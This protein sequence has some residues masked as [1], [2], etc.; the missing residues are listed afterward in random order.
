MDK[1]QLIPGLPDDLACE[2][3]VRVSVDDFS[4]VGAVCNKWNRILGSPLFDKHRKSVGA[5]RPIVVLAQLQPR[6]HSDRE[7]SRLLFRV[8]LFEPAT[9]SWSLAPPIPRRSSGLPLFCKLV[10]LGRK[11][12]VLGGWNPLT[13]ANTDEVHIYDMVSRTWRCGATMP[14]PPRSFFACAA[15]QERGMVFVAGGRDARKKALRSALAYDVAADAW[16]RMP[17]MALRRDECS[18]VFAGGAFHVLSGYPTEAQVQFSRSA[19][20]FDVVAW[21]W[22]PVEEGK[23]EE[24]AC[25]WTSVVGSDGMVYMCLQSGEVVVLEEEGGNRGGRAWRRMAELPA[26]MRS[27]KRMVAWEGGMMVLGLGSQKEEQVAYVL[28]IK[29]NEPKTTWRKVEMPKEFS[30][31][32]HAACCSTI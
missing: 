13:W 8:S 21:R 3:L 15:W 6:L 5:A 25:P 7:A 24:E 30:G 11:L 22:G 20:S 27:A 16:I 17:D 19:E 2:C 29:G 18:G 31:H 12:V 1:D 23:L 28:E 26:E 32:V 4:T 14:G 9:R 10:A